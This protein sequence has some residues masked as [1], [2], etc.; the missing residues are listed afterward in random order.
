MAHSDLLKMSNIDFS[1]ITLH[2]LVRGLGEV[3]GV[4][5]KFLLFLVATEGMN[6]G[7]V[8]G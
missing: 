5:P 7:F 8:G 2:A 3:G 4:A 6:H 1:E